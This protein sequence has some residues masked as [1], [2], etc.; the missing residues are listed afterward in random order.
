MAGSKT[1]K[2][3]IQ[4]AGQLDK[5]LANAIGTA[6]G[7]VSSLSRT[8]SQI[9]T[10]G[11]AAMGAFTTGTVRFLDQ[12]TKEAAAFKNGLAD[13]VKYIEGLADAAGKVSNEIAGYREDF[14]GNPIPVTYAENYAEF[15][16]Y[17]RDLSTQIP[18]TQSELQKLAAAAGQSGYSFDKMMG[19]NFLRDV[20]MWGAAMDIDAATAGDWAAKWEVALNMTHDQ[21]MTLADQINYLGANNAT[22]AAEI[23]GVVNQ[24][25]SFGQIAGVL[26]EETAALATALLAAGVG[27]DR[28]GTS[29]KRMYSNMT[30]GS[31]ATKA[32]I[33]LWNSMGLTAKGV[34]EGMQ[35]DAAGMIQTVLDSI[36]KIPKAEQAAALKVLFGQWAGP[37]A[38]KLLTN[39]DT[40]ARALAD[41][42]NPE[43]YTGS[44]AR[45]FVI[46][47][48]T[49]EAVDMMLGS[50]IS[51]LTGEIGE[52][53]LPAKKEM[54]L[55][56]ID[57]ISIMRNDMPEIKEIS[58]ILGTMFSDGVR[59]AGEA[60]QT[61]LPHI[62]QGLEYLANNG[63]QVVAV[64]KGMAGTFI[65]MKSAPLLENLF[66]GAGG[67]LFG[68]SPPAG[69]GKSGG[70]LGSVKDLWS[71]G[72]N[73]PGKLS[74]A[75]GTAWGFSRDFLGAATTD[76]K[77]YG[78]GNVLRGLLGETKLGSGL[79][80]YFGGIKGDWGNL[81]N[82]GIG[83]GIA[84][85]VTGTSGVTKEILSGISQAT[86]LTDLVNGAIGL[87]KG[88]AGWLSGKG[89][90]LLS[91][92]T[93]SAPAKALGG[94]AGT[95]GRIGGTVFPQIS[96]FAGAGAG[97]LGSVWGPAAGM[98]GGLFTGA[99]PIVG[100]ISAVI[101]VVSLLNDKFGLMDSIFNQLFGEEGPDKLKAFQTTMD[102]LFDGSLIETGM[103]SLGQKIFGVFDPFT[104]TYQ[105]GLLSNLFPPETTAMFMT[106]FNAIPPIL[107]SVM[108]VV[109]QIVSFS[110]GTVKPIIQD[111][112][113][114]ITETV[115]P[116]LLQTFTDAAPYIA[117]IIDGLGSG[118]MAG[119][120]TIGMVIQAVMPIVQGLITVFLKVGSVVIPALL[121]GVSVFATG[122]GNIMGFI[123]GI[124]NGLITFIT[125]VFSGNWRQAWQGVKDIFGNA[126][127]ALVEL[128]K[129]PINAVIA[130]INGVFDKLRGLSFT[131]PDWSPI[132][133]GA[134]IGF[135]WLPTLTPL[136]KGGFT[137]GPSLA[138]EAG[139]EAVISFQRGVRG[140][141]IAT[142]MQAGRMLGISEIEASKAAGV[143]LKEIDAPITRG[144]P[145]GGQIV[146]APQINIQGNAD[147]TVIDQALAEAEARFRTWYE[148]MERQKERKKY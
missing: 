30:A 135:N 6:Q 8:I 123:Q 20:A 131:I 59:R 129:T 7:Q 139:R 14:T 126:F 26:P 45:E 111:S 27:S 115:M 31:S 58:D 110:T 108:G 16:K 99:L 57:F 55:A 102:G 94:A 101:A 114:F 21:V 128:C 43:K 85:T 125:G 100:G 112:F 146:F 147:R 93:G 49:P 118:I 51:A 15:S 39:R 53:F 144:G 132:G 88:G 106:A 29:V 75:L 74:G 127:N 89:T 67:L 22:T 96:S 52:S 119:M 13:D 86:G 136:A 138:G 124:F 79:V 121:A 41:M 50:S 97:L 18:Y 36:E 105:G 140:Q 103:R 11:L 91:A 66:S 17:I 81:L 38:A 44:M 25:A 61:A 130:I 34:A 78:T 122:I 2:L 117:T 95:V 72:Q 42:Q 82:T 87:T 69:V 1:L 92:I 3:S 71:S 9:G 134:E 84:K 46:K 23:A 76:A 142:W 148:E 107:Q 120:Q 62:R 68:T 24:A 145:G 35:Q 77:L 141:N 28:V 63:T 48:D 5:S 109:G 4:I 98:F 116:I 37:D 80:G 19:T 60:M 54:S 47:S 70:L 137:N 104:E 113:S 12:C 65:A 73:A 32:Q 40:F 56:V 133:A 143:Q 10:V 33:E 90:G 64:I 83:G